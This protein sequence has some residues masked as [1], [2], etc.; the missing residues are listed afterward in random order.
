MGMPLPPAGHAS[1]SSRIFR[2]RATEEP[3][4][5]LRTVTLPSA[6]HASA[7]TRISRRRATEE[8]MAPLRTV[9]LPSAGHANVFSFIVTIRF[10]IDIYA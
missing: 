8:P 5:P 1:A 10:V 9:T 3:M 2:R 7:S 6:G 4:A